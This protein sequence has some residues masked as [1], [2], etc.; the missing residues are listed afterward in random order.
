MHKFKKSDFD[1]ELHV[2][3]K[4]KITLLHHFM[5]PDDVVSGMHYHVLGSELSQRGWEVE[6]LPSNRAC[7]NNEARFK[8]YEFVDGVNYKRIWR[9]RISQHSFLGRL[10]NSAWMI[11][12]WSRIAF[13]RKEN[14]PQVVL[15]GTDPVFCVIVAKILKTFAPQIKIAHWCFD[16]HPE[17]SLAN[18]KF[19][20]DNIIV[21]F[22]KKLM[23]IGYN[24]CDLIVDIGPCMRERLRKYH[25]CAS[26]D[27]MTP[28]A[29]NEPI[30]PV[31]TNIVI[32]KK[33]FGNAKLG[34]LYSGN[35]GEAHDY[36]NFLALARAVR[37][38]IDV[39]F[40]LSCRGNRVAE[41]KAAVNNSDTNISFVDFVPVDQLESHLS[42][43]DIHMVC[44]NKN[45]S[46]VAVPSKFF[47]S[48]ASGRP[49]LYSGPKD[50]S[51]A[52][53]I[54]IFDI[55]WVLDGDNISYINSVF[56]EIITNKKV[57]QNMNIRCH[58]VYNDHFSL[59]KVASAWNDALVK[60][61]RK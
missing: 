60:L 6:A 23:K 61:V 56:K 54:D 52:K 47:G 37:D 5:Y 36:I 55:G 42:S 35:F 30:F 19:K 45:W 1:K 9:P 34:I 46:G 58:K 53:W 7:W 39:H 51:I 31:P 24:S 50:S 57:M 25:H 8:K 27:Q 59:S 28:W 48:I 14:M 43:A 44:L 20:P 12:S 11:F 16:L 17:A 26:E 3:K 22:V 13:R 21:L 2:P 33:L 40:C 49:V 18:L 15:I 38:N 29:I 4:N 41:L 10:F 32:R